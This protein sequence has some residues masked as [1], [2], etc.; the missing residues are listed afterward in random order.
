MY[1]SVL[2]YRSKSKL[3]FSLCFA[4]D[5]MNQASCTH[6]DKERCIVGTWV[7]DEFQ[8]T[9]DMGYGLVDVIE[10]WQYKLRC[11]DNDTN[12]GGPFAEYV[13]MFLIL[14]QESSGYPSRVQSEE[15]KDKY[16]E[17]YRGAEGIASDKTSISKNVGQRTLAKL[18][19]SSMYCKW[20]QNRNNTQQ[21]LLP[22]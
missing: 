1:H 11:Y 22:Q 20:P 18:K 17:D 5:T 4:C 8:K 9:V 21:N 14:K 10:F 15:D 13:N 12:S 7:M 6:S 19:L 2:P 3:I 16:N